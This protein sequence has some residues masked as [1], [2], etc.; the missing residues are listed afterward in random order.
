MLKDGQEVIYAELKEN[1]RTRRFVFPVEESLVDKINVLQHETDVIVEGIGKGVIKQSLVDG[2]DGVAEALEAIPSG[3][4]GLYTVKFKNHPD[5]PEG[6]ARYSEA[7]LEYIN[8]VELISPVAQEKQIKKEPDLISQLKEQLEFQTNGP[9][10]PDDAP[11]G[12]M[13]LEDFINEQKEKKM[14]KKVS[15]RLALE[16]LKE[17]AAKQKGSEKLPASPTSFVVSEE[18]HEHI[19]EILELSYRIL[20]AVECDYDKVSGRELAKWFANYSYENGAD[21]AWDLIASKI[22][23]W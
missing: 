16:S 13:N 23:E 19:E 5:I 6:Q 18:T 10:S 15:K 3:V 12:E 17:Q 1:G 22:T 11:K 9:A 7:L 4:N 14:Q 8:G 21:K 20:R 2:A